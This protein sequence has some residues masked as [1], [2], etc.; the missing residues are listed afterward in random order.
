MISNNGQNKQ[1]PNE[2]TSTFKELQVLKHLRKWVKIEPMGLPDDLMKVYSLLVLPDKKDTLLAGT[3]NGVMISKDGGENWQMFDD[4]RLITAMTV[5]PNGKDIIGYSM[6]NMV[7]GLMITK[8]NGQSWE[9]VGLD[10][11]KV[12]AS[13]ISVNQKDDQQIAVST[14]NTSLYETKDGG[15]NW[16][17]IISSGVL[18]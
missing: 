2:L 1:L 9:G 16:D 18:N 12:A 5:M 8:D 7:S 11:G 14:F 10:L 15:K 17:K 4:T 6:S 3:E 13:S